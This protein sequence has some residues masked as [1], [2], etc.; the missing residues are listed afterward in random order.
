MAGSRPIAFPFFAE[1]SSSAKGDKG[2]T[3][4]CLWALSNQGNFCAHE[5]AD[6]WEMLSHLKDTHGLSLNPKLDF[7]GA[8]QQIYCNR[9]ETLQHQLSCHILCYEDFEVACE[10]PPKSSHTEWLKDIF[11][12]LKE[13]RK[14]IMSKLLFGDDFP[15]DEEISLN[16]SNVEAA[17]ADP[18]PLPDLI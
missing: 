4:T 6:F 12:R 8:C 7:C 18:E 3:F 1:I 17:V 11:E 5:G 10:H 15:L 14:D 2:P 13:V 16:L 9:L